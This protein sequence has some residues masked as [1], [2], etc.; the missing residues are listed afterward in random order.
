MELLQR[1]FFLFTVFT[2]WHFFLTLLHSEQPK[3][4]RVMA[5]LSAKGLSRETNISVLKMSL[6]E[7]YAYAL[8]RFDSTI[9]LIYM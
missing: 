7:V 1:F 5:I 8:N 3:L 6:L 9:L 2:Q 4:Y